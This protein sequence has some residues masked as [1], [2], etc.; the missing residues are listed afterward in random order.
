[1]YLKNAV[2]STTKSFFSLRPEKTMSFWRM[3]ICLRF[4]KANRLVASYFLPFGNVG[5]S[6][7]LF[8]HFFTR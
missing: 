4:W 2:T 1:M 5:Y 8:V 3:G 7:S 6:F